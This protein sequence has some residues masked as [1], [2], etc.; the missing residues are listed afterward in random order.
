MSASVA[1]LATAAAV[2][3][4][5]VLCGGFLPT[6]AALVVDES[7]AEFLSKLK[8]ELRV[9]ATGGAASKLLSHDRST[10]KITLPASWDATGGNSWTHAVV[11]EEHKLIFCAMPKCGSTQWRKM[12][13]RLNGAEKN[14]LTRD[15]HNPAANGLQL[16]NKLPLSKVEELINDP[17]YTKAVFVRSPLTRLLSG[18]RDKLEV[19]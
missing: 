17:E 15:P 10:D 14:Y 5:F 6:A 3:F 13:R 18:F 9:D 1:L 4:A 11:L 16:L 8:K 2:L 7:P 19:G 12:L